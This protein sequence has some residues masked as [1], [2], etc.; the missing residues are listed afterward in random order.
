M[1]T[2][3]DKADL[4][5]LVRE[6]W[7]ELG[8]TIDRLGEQEMIQPGVEGEW[9][10][11]DLLAHISAWEALMVQWV[12]D[13]LRGD[14]PDRPAPDE[15]WEDL[16]EVNERLFRERVDRPL[17]EVLAAFHQTH[18]QAYQ[19]VAGLSE[20]DLFDPDRF[21]WRRGDPLWH[22]VA[23]NTWGHYRE[24]QQA[25]ERWIDER[26]PPGQAER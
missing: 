24:H 25:I 14:T 4:L 18:Q 10:V 15:P 11:K 23:G 19:T 8:A 21:A 26:T 7:A 5:A 16:D 2:P 9:S 3:R 1:D 13:S 12:G 20:A 22:L 6:S 17:E